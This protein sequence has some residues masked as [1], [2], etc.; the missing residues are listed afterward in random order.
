MLALYTSFFL[1]FF[2]FLLRMVTFLFTGSVSACFLVWA[3]L[4]AFDFAV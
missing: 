1:L 3:V 2:F 4:V